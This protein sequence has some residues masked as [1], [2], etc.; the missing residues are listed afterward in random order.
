LQDA[1]ALHQSGHLAQ[2]RDIYERILQEQPAHSDAMNLLGAIALQTGEPA[3]ALELY[4]RVI[5]ID[6][7]NAAAWCNGGFASAQLGQL[8]AAL[9]HYDQAIAL[10]AHYPEAYLYRGNTLAAMKRWDAALAN[11]EQAIALQA[12]YSEAYSNRGVALK[13]LDRF[14]AALAS[15]DQAIALRSDYAE[16]YANRGN[17]L[18]ELGQWDA[19]RANY[20]R[21]IALRPDYPE[22]HVS[23]SFLS[24]LHGNLEDGWIDYEWRFKM[25]AGTKRRFVQPLWLGNESIAGRTILLYSE[26]GLGDALQFCRYAKVV[27]DLG[28]SVILQVRKPLKSLLAGVQGASQVIT[29]GDL[30]PRFDC[31]CPLMSLP[32]AFKTTLDTIP[33]ASR[34]LTSNPVKV[35]KWLARLGSSPKSRIGLVWSGNPAF[36]L[37]RKRS[38]ALTELLRHLPV[39]PQYVSLQKE[40][41]T[42]DRLTIQAH[43]G[44]LQFADELNDF[45]DTASLCECL[46]LVISVDT[47]VAHLSGAMGKKTW[48]LLPSVPDW[49]WLLN[50]EDSPWYPSVR[51]YRQRGRGDWGGVLDRI[52]ADLYALTQKGGAS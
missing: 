6:P 50:R 14:D 33:V 48:I 24:L 49:R 39:G 17:A 27:A 3:R 51:L 7:T 13:T 4:R 37:D 30:M 44:I 26:Q 45:S 29:G 28:A 2:A 34:Y 16:A 15:F 36:S 43:G 22:P 31:R 19:A 23:R 52:E 20:E 11:Y 8:D 38:I 35:D 21:A 12:D 10:R 18:Y 41:T 47:A 9:D 46:D 40:L 42:L 25:G 32:L 5:K 1:L